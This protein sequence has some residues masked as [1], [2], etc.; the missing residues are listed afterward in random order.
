MNPG[1]QRVFS[2]AIL[3]LLL[4]QFCYSQVDLVNQPYAGTTV[5]GGAASHMSELGDLPQA[6][7][8]NLEGLLQESFGEFRDSV[9]FSHGQIVAL[10]AY[11]KKKEEAY[12]QEWIAPK[13][14]LVFVL[15]DKS[16][17]I[18]ALNIRLR[19]DAHGQV[20]K[21]DWPREGYSKRS[22]LKPLKDVLAF[23]L[24]EYGL[25][26]TDE[27]SREYDLSYDDQGHMNFVIKIPRKNN[28]RISD[29]YVINWKTLKLVDDLSL[30]ITTY[31]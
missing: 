25:E 17:N 6:I 18:S 24:K 2:I 19:L 10:E 23:A 29:A 5:Y 14:D 26:K 22:S 16:L 4:C 3:H 20:L 21:F 11:F 7:L 30:V 9:H 13:Y 27:L 8:Q 28:D 31:H 12:R 15:R 1:F